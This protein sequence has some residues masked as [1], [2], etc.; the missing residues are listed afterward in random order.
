[1]ELGQ[2]KTKAK[3]E[4]SDLEALGLP[5]P[6]LALME[7]NREQLEKNFI[8]IDQKYGRSEATRSRRLILA[9]DATYL[10][11]GLTQHRRGEEC[12]LIGGPWSPSDESNCWVELGQNSSSLPRAPIM[13]EWL[14]WDP[15]AVHKLSLSA[16]SMPMSLKPPKSEDETLVH[17]GNWESCCCN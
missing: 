8:L 14:L 13:M 7:M 10:L 11:K 3:I 17:A 2:K 15:N 6:S 12:R 4:M 9:M 5:D 1:M 16:A